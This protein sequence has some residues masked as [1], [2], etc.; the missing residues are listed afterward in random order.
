MLKGEGP[1]YGYFLQGKKS[2]MVVSE[3]DKDEAQNV[4][5]GTEITAKSRAR[6]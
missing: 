2:L 3:H 1:K 4:L 5:R 6:L